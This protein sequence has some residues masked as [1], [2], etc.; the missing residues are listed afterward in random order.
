MAKAATNVPRY[1]SSTERRRTAAV[2]GVLEGRGQ[3]LQEDGRP[4]GAVPRTGNHVTV[5]KVDARLAAPA[6]LGHPR[7]PLVARRE[8]RPVL[9]EPDESPPFLLIGDDV[10]GG[11]FAINGGGLG[12]EV[13]KAHYFAPDSLSWESL[14]VGYTDFLL[15]C[16]S[17]E[18]SAVV[19][20]TGPPVL[21]AGSFAWGD[22]FLASCR[23]RMA[24]NLRS[25]PTPAAGDAGSELPGV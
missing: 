7:L 12:E 20:E 9:R 16:F 14:G 8:P 6:G 24:R 17:G 18:P 1:S 25:P 19:V 3:P 21:A 22:D 11:F 4:E 10:V 15:W 13:G 23:Y 5:R 2:L